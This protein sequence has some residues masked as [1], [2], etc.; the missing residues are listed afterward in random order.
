MRK[1]SYY[2]LLCLPLWISCTE[3]KQESP[4]TLWYTEPAKNWNE[5]LP[6]GNGYVGAMVFSTVETE[7]LQLNE[8]TLYAGEPNQYEAPKITPEM[9]D[10][11]VALIKAKKYPEA[12]EM[13]R[14]H[15]LGRL[16]QPYQPFGDLFIKNNVNGEVSNYKRELN[17]REAIVH[18]TYTQNGIA[19]E[20]EVFASN[21]DKTIVV[22][23]KSSTPDGIDVHL[24]FT[25][26]HPTAKQQIDGETLIVKGQAPGYLSNRTLE[27]LESWGNKDKHPE[28]FDANGNRKFDKRILYAD[29]I[30]GKGMFFEGQLKPVFPNKGVAKK[31][32][33][34]LHISGTDEVYF[35]ISLATSYNGFDKSPSRE[36]IDP[37]AK[38]A[39]QLKQATA[40]AYSDLKERHIADYSHLF[41]R[42]ELTLPS[43]IEQLSLP[44]DQ[45]IVNF[46]AKSDPAL[47]ALLFQFGR[48]LMI[49]GSRPGGQ[50]LNLQ[51]IWNK[52]VFPPWASAYT[53]NINAEMNYWPAELTNLSEC[54]E[55]FFDM[56]KELSI[57][58]KVTAQER[59]NRRGWAAHHNTNI[60]RIAFPND[61]QPTASFW[62]MVQ[63]WLCSHLWERYLFT[64]DKDFLKNRA[65]PL[66][67]GAAAFYADWL[68][69]DG[70]GH[71]VTPV[72]ASPENTFIT[73]D[74]KRA[75]LSM[76]PTMDMAIIRETFSRTIKAAEMLN[77]D[78]E[79]VS[80]LKEKHSKLLPYQIG[81]R[82]Q[83]QE[84]MYDFKEQDP[85]H[86][87][88]SH[89]YGFHPGDQITPDGTPE[90]FDA[91]KQSLNLRGDA[92]NGW[93]M[94]WKI[95]MW[96]RQLDGN[97]AYKIISN[98]F[99]P[100]E[101]APK[102]KGIIGGLYMNMFDAC[103]P[104]QIDGNFGYTAGVAEMLLQSHAGYIHLLPALPNVWAEGSVSGLKARG[105]FE[106][107]M[108][109][110]AGKLVNASLNSKNGAPCVLRAEVPFR[111]T[112]DGKEVA[113]SR[114]VK[115]NGKDYYQVNFDTEKGGLY[116]L[117]MDN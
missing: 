28:L 58:G 71:L 73:D 11:V 23:L 4:L 14:K 63:G 111:V 37:T 49:S 78:A 46:S 21:P 94:G 67:K 115:S 45:R 22:R 7:Q 105:N 90:L 87:H 82:G 106:V 83:L 69:E 6:I 1:I 99:N 113:A 51:G 17:L 96:A 74:N 43:Q 85:L 34:G 40:H 42:V 109:W 36:G 12:N 81:S 86:R 8:N 102:R 93:S 38:A 29:E 100:V 39:A 95:N 18:T 114:V 103:P 116:Q 5:A 68:I 24:N 77:V 89:L 79:L 26:P 56:I 84:W 61:N 108:K 32:A 15:W 55:P 44:T 59:Y 30:D 64:G 97:H 3:T 52:E 72:G 54:H 57:N 47:A 66:M 107:A 91:V 53:Q 80:E 98:L 35:V 75:S 31:T 70:E 9:L 48:Y 13:V 41:S 101:F 62:P 20:R 19:Y 65:Y 33:E 10:R 16:H 27:Q 117:V 2:L 60:W 104:F 110:T 25:S 88:L 50:P 76:G 92:A 112:A